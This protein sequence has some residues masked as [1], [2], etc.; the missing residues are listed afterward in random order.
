ME[1]QE[2]ENCWEKRLQV[3][4]AELEGL[5][6]RGQ[7]IRYLIS[8]SKMVASPSSELLQDRFRLPNCA[9]GVWLKPTRKEGRRCWEAYAESELILGILHLLARIFDGLAE[10]EVPDVPVNL[11]SQPPFQHI[12]PQ[13]KRLGLNDLL[14]IYLA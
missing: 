1:Q 6:G 3:V 10:H 5:T 2:V 12:V 14:K 13:S 7:Q 4:A 9:V 11:L 8:Q